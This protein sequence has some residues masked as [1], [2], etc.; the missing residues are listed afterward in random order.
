MNELR[1]RRKELG[2]T[3]AQA[4][5]ACGVSRRTYQ[6]Y[7][8]EK[9]TNQDVFNSLLEQLDSFGVFDKYSR[10]VVSIKFI[11]RVAQDIFTEYPEIESAYLYGSYARGEAT[12]ESDVDIMVI[13]PPMGLKFYGL[14]GRLE[15]AIHKQIDLQTFRQIKDNPDFVEQLL[16]EGVRIYKK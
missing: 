10:Y 16:K 2:L 1:K 6:T 15:D 4:A 12:G 13:C 9:Y 7:E 11:T 14:A 5:E 3:Q 8:E